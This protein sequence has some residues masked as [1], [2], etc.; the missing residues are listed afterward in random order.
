MSAVRDE[1]G[2]FDKRPKRK[3]LP[4]RVR[5]LLV[6]FVFALFALL[7]VAVVKDIAS[8]GEMAE[9]VKIDGKAVGGSSKA[10]ALETARRAVARYSGPVTI[11]FEGGTHEVDMKSIDF[12]ANPEAMVQMAYLQGRGWFVPWR[13]FKRLFGMSSHVDVPVVFTYEE[14]A[15]KKRVKEIAGAVDRDPE[16]VRISVASGSPDVVPSKDGVKTKTD[17]SVKEVASR[18]TSEDRRVDLSVDYVKPELT[19]EDVGKIVIIDKSEF[20]LYLYDREEYMSDYQVAVGMPAYPTP[21]GKFHIYFKE[22]N[23]TWLPTSEWAKDKQG[24][25]QPPGPDNPLGG[26][27]MDLGSGIGIHATPFE[28]SLGEQASHGCIRMSKEGAAELYDEVKVGTPVFIV[29]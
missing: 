7:I 26:Y 11:S 21:T 20:A 19:E 13:L 14:K 1:P 28:K 29:D 16:S 8:T 9:G 15:L 24:I 5:L 10:K 4:P 17:A 22:K 12:K 25:P 3:G 2:E 18:L 27:W 23:P 6:I